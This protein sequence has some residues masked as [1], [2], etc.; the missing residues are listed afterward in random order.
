MQSHRNHFFAYLKSST[1]LPLSMS[2]RY[3]LS[4]S[5]EL[6][7]MKTTPESVRAATSYHG[8]SFLMFYAIPGCPGTSIT[9]ATSAM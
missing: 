7:A 3:A 2:K 8:L 5:A 1:V 9:Q 6:P 4:V